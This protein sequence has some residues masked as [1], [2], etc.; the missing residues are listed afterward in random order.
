MLIRKLQNLFK[1]Q[2]SDNWTIKLVRVVLTIIALV[3]GLLLA[4]GILFNVAVVNF[5][6]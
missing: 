4:S 2:A 5:T 3:L 1:L 6:N